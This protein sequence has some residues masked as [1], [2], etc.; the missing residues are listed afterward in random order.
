MMKKFKIVCMIGSMKFYDVM[1]QEET[2]LTDMGYIVLHPVKS[3]YEH[4][5]DTLKEQYDAEIRVKI[6]MADIVYVIDV[7]GYIGDSTKSEIEY[8]YS[9][10]KKVMQYSDKFYEL[11]NITDDVL[12]RCCK[13][14]DAPVTLIGSA[15]FKD[16]FNDVYKTLSRLGF[17][18]YMPSIFSFSSDEVLEFT[19]RQHKIFDELHEHKISMSKYVLCVDGSNSSER[20]IGTDTKKEIKFIKSL[21]MNLEPTLLY[22]SSNGLAQLINSRIHEVCNEPNSM[23]L[24]GGKQPLT[25]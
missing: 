18:V 13:I 24:I 7:D 1:L 5:S 25:V 9:A 3:G 6:D 8:A 21:P 11:I 23:R 10:G 14:N 2:R 22:T 20:Y 19:D 12:D 4:I 15:R 16:I 17:T